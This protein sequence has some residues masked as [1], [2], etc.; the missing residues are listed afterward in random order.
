[1]AWVTPKTDW[2]PTDTFNLSPDYDRIKGNIEYLQS[3]GKTMYPEFSIKVMSAYDITGFPYPSFLNTIVE[4]TQTVAERTWMPSG[5][6]P[7]AT[8][9][10]N[11]PAW[12]DADLNAIEGNLLMTYNVLQG[13]F[14]VLPKLSFDLGGT[15][16]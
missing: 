5:F 16:F 10:G 1:M 3:F 12:N 6:L 14:A 7:M 11:Q 2:K 4:N 8:Y 15:E 13:Q 9:E